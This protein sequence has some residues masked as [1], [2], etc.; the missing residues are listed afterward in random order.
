MDVRYEVNERLKK[1]WI[2]KDRI[3]YDLVRI[4]DFTPP[5]GAGSYEWCTTTKLLKTFKNK[6]E[7]D[8]AKFDKERAFL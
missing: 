4:N 5:N 1:S 8:D 2:F 7:A 3:V 6:K